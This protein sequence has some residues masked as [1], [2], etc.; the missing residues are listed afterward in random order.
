MH[1]LVTGIRQ[2]EETNDLTHRFDLGSSDE[3]GRVAR[4]FD[5]L[6]NK[7]EGILR[8][9][10]A[11]V[12]QIDHAADHVGNSSQQ[13]AGGATEQ[14]AN[15]E[16]ISVSLEEMSGKTRENARSSSKAAGLAEESQ[17][18]ASTGQNEMSQ[19]TAAMDEIKAS[20]DM[21]SKIIKVS[22]EVAFQT[23]LLA[24]NAAVE[25]A[26]AGDAGKGF[27]VV[28]DEVRNLAMR[29]ANAA[30]ET[31]DMIQ[32]ST[33]RVDKGVGIAS[34]V[35][36]SLTGIADSTDKVTTLLSEIAAASQE[37]AD[38]IVQVNVAIQE[39]DRV[40]Q[41]SAG[42][43]EELASTA[44]ETAVQ[45]NSLRGIVDQF[46]VHRSEPASTAADV[47]DKAPKPRATAEPNRPAPVEAVARL[48]PREEHEEDELLIES[49]SNDSRLEEF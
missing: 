30:R 6:M 13:M 18:S 38:G 29:S 37:Q 45:C 8:G 16:E 10:S 1:V 3:I 27:A 5:A 9:V 12:E 35:G 21:I 33:H 11:G 24:L 39:L 23:N 36:E 31:A 14:A 40:T 49:L 46:K 34:R 41:Q 20:S 28:A 26:R 7:M 25:A 42:N 4:S 15:I 22:D 32:E 2:V 47:S 19:M 48:I 17:S 44:E 43:A